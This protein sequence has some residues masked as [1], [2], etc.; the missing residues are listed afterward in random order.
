[1]IEVPGPRAPLTHL[2]QRIRRGI[3][4]V[5]GVVGFG[6]S[7]VALF[8]Q[9]DLI[10]L[11][12]IAVLVIPMAVWVSAWFARRYTQTLL[13]GSLALFLLGIVIIPCSA[14]FLWPRLA[15]IALALAITAATTGGVV[16]TALLSIFGV[17]LVFIDS[18]RAVPHGEHISTTL[19][20]QLGTS[21]GIVLIAPAMAYL[22]NLWTRVCAQRDTAANAARDREARALAAGRASAVGS[23]VDRRIHETVLNTLG[24]IARAQIDQE[25]ARQQCINDLAELD[26]L[27]V[28]APRSVQDM[29]ALLLERHP[30]PG[31]ILSV[32]HSDV[33]FYDDETAQVAFDAVGEALR[34]VVRHSGATRTTLR[35][36]AQSRHITFVVIDDGGGMDASAQERFG[37][38][39]ALTDAITSVGGDVR[40][41]SAL[42]QG[43]RVEISLP[44]STPR[45]AAPRRESAL[46]VLLGPAGARLAMLP[47]VALGLLLLIPIALTFS[48]PWTIAA[49][50][51][52]FAAVVL[53]LG[54]HWNSGYA[55]I[56][57]WI[58]LALLLTTQYAAW[59]TLQGCDSA[60]G[61]HLILFAT[62]GAMVLPALALRQLALSGLLLAA[63]SLPTITIPWALPTT[64][65]AEA[66]IPAVETTIWVALLVGI[67][68]LLSTAVDRSD[69]SQDERWTEIA[70]ADA[71]RIAREAAD[72]RWR[73][74]DVETR[75]LLV[76]VSTGAAAIWQPEVRSAAGRLE[77]RLRSLLE[78]ARIGNA[79][80]RTSLE[81][82]VEL[83]NTH[84][85]AL[86]MTVIDDT[87]NEE[88]PAEVIDSLVAV[89]C[90]PATDSMSLT[91]LDGEILVSA[92]RDALTDAGLVDLAE[93][94][95]D[96]IY[97]ASLAWANTDAGPSDE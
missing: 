22:A 93:T 95:H 91:V 36:T 74:V 81:S 8:A 59:S 77:N 10:D 75:A 12:D 50:Y 13:T 27:T 96:D 57:S 30:V 84:G 44:M 51:L 6:P 78:T 15:G 7:V 38:R 87:W 29:L 37:M 55:A 32:V 19:L 73:S 49:P 20:D 43:T 53:W 11:V 23:A 41:T 1:M 33:R 26:S 47:A 67:I 21:L 34:N 70:L 64:C 63:V 31:P 97:V 60:G 14:G 39:R 62:A 88:P 72:E 9:R 2:T 89:A 40:I 17:V 76:N 86:S 69:A 85:T 68:A 71:Q 4:A 45:I 35:A 66:A 52:A 56:L 80:G 16:T 79:T 25:A 46:N 28:A 18:D 48:A 90:N 42:G 61:L 65:R 58:S 83:A 3:A 82:V 54:A 24:A 92:P 5:S 94:E